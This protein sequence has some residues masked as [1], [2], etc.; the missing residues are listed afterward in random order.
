M[1][2][3]PEP[4]SSAVSGVRRKLPVAAT[5]RPSG[6][7]YCQSGVAVPAPMSRAYSTP[8]RADTT[9]MVVEHAHVLDGWVGVG[10]S[11]RRAGHRIASRYRR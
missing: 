4:M 11:G 10:R 8:R 7:A 1:M 9:R 6:W 5:D 3:L 2:L